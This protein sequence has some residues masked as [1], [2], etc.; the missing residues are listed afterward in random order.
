M[1][2][3]QEQVS[4]MNL[5]QKDLLKSFIDVCMK[6]NLKYYMVHGSLLGTLKYGDFFPLDDDIDVAMPREDYNKLLEFGQSLLPDNVFLQSCKS[7]KEYPMVFAKLR[8]NNTAFIQTLMKGLNINQGIYIDIFPIDYYPKNRFKKIWLRFLDK[9]YLSRIGTRINYDSGEAKWKKIIRSI[10]CIF[11]PSWEKAVKKRAGLYAKFPQSDRV[12][13][14]GG[15][16]SEQGIPSAWF[17]NGEELEFAGLSVRCPQMHKDY[18]TCIYGD[19]M[20]YNPSEK[21]INDDGTVT[22]SA[23][24]FSTTQSY[25]DFN[26][27]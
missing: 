14:I 25:L 15:K 20:N 4:A 5:I 6:L 7:E 24:V 18:M 10:S 21:N 17:G 8:D 19:Y 9:L 11:C 1:R 13:V 2:L 26:G 27:I 12:I 16:A 3:T 23:E 22:V